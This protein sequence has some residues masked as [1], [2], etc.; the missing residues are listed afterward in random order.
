MSETGEPRSDDDGLTRSLAGQV[1][2][3]AGW[4]I[5][6]RFVMR[7][8]GFANTIIVARL[9][10]PAD[11]G[12]VAVG[13]TAMQLLQGFSDLGVSQ[14]V[15][16]FRDAGRD[17]LDTL[18]TL[19][20]LRGAAVAAL[21]LI[22]GPI[23]ARFYG[24]PRMA[25]VFAGMALYALFLGLINPKFFEFQR[26]LDFSKEFISE[27]A[28]K[29]FSVAVSIAVA[30]A[31]RTYWAIVLGV[32]AAGAA[33]LTLSYAMH[34]YRP[35]PTLRSLRKV[36][37]F[38]G[39][40]TGV[41]FFAALNNKLDAFV[42]ART[43]GAHETGKFFVGLQ[44]AELPTSEL[45]API[46]RAVYPGLSA[47]QS[48]P[49]RMRAAYLR[50]VEALGAVALPAAIGFAFVS[51]DALV[52]LLGEKWE[53]AAF[54]ISALT[55]VMGIQTLLLATQAYAMALGRT[56]LIFFRELTFFLVRTPIFIYA[57]L[58]HGLAG[59]V[60][61][62]AGCGL[63]HVGLSLAVYARCSGKL[64]IDPL[65]AARRS[66]AA[67]AIMAAFFIFL[68]PTIH[69]ALGAPL[70]WRLA[71]DIVSGAVLYG[72]SLFGV[73]RLEGAPDGVERLAFGALRRVGTA[74]SGRLTA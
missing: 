30:V 58:H 1:A 14:A 16:R 46:A 69:A 8:L 13:V 62:A 19:S 59:A 7:I 70:P 52:F 63:V 9:L 68:R 23:A 49:E 10:T 31:F 54:V 47:M 73:W 53:G 37:G 55:P 24:E 11:F 26:R 41:S 64:F 21:L 56:H 74:L 60:A 36:L 67:I 15:V 20:A 32:V 39:W 65:F 12:L 44:I 28:T 40:L 38:S 66:F 72:A 34:P 45:A 18:F 5:A 71:L 2:K 3:S 43:V 4:I 25:P 51:H 27:V 48:A 42:L 57:A 29:L 17:D 22:A 6:A 61:A 35:K 33:Q 50:G